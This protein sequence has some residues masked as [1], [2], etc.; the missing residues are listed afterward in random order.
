MH[1]ETR[2]TILAPRPTIE[3]GL[4]VVCGLF[5]TAS[6]AGEDSSVQPFDSNTDRV[7]LFTV[8]P[9]YPEEARRERIEGEVQVC[10]DI[11]RKGY[12]R[13]IAVR[14]SR[15]APLEKGREL[16]A[17]KACRTFRFRLVRTAKPAAGRVSG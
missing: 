5:A 17:I 12:P 2:Q 9:D 4:L 7:P 10:F 6:L 13:R 11:S 14:R 16:A 1:R 15:F 8:I 3:A